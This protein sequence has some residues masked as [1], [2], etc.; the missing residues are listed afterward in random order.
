MKRRFFAYIIAGLVLLFCIP[1]TGHGDAGS[2]AGDSNFGSFSDFGGGG[3]SFSDPGS[4]VFDAGN[5]FTDP[6]YGMFGHQ[7]AFGSEDSDE[8]SLPIIVV[9][10]AG[11]FGG[12]SD[13]GGGSDWDSGSSWDDDSDW[14]SGSSWS[15]SYSSDSGT[16]TGGFPFWIVVVVIVGV[17]V[18]FGRNKKK[19]THSAPYTP[20]APVQANVQAALANLKQEDPLFSEAEILRKVSNGY[21]QMQEAWQ[22]KAWE[23]MRMLLTD[24]LFNQFAAQLKPYIDNRR[25]N[26]VERIAVLSTAIVGCGK[27]E[28]NDSLTVR[29]QARIN[30]YVVDDVTGNVVS[31]DPN[32]ELFM[33]YEWTL[34]RA[35]GK[36]TP[37]QDETGHISCPNC[38]APLSISQSA[39]CSY[40]GTVVTARDYDWVVSAIR[41][42]SQKSG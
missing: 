2:F 31:G 15:S 13:W 17:L 35:L 38:G 11:N 27:D 3:D 24:E 8:Q 40:C 41:G 37:E 25:T 22:N 33:T 23:P 14:D 42:I 34:I 19:G 26:R 39:K 9:G 28:V 20:A 18:L 4:S 21:I 36:K 16:S 12:D 32:R 7:S 10:D 1:I 30:D 5:A 6:S 29:V